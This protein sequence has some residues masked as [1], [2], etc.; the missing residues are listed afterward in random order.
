VL[1]FQENGLFSTLYL[2]YASNMLW[3]LKEQFFLVLGKTEKTYFSTM[4]YY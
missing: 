1:V 3:A 2:Y 4:N